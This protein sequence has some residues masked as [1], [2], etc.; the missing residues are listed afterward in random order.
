[1]SVEC[2]CFHSFVIISLFL[3]TEIIFRT[4]ISDK[5]S[6]KMLFTKDKPKQIIGFCIIY[7]YAERI[8]NWL[9]Y[10]WWE[11]GATE[12]RNTDWYFFLQVLICGKNPLD[13]ADFNYIYTE[14]MNIK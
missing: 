2:Y 7:I 1:M 8:T 11:T 14:T 6:P 3:N 5:V 10:K 9:Y 4:F 12:I 13:N